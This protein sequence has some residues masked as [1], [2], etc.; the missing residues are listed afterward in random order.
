MDGSLDIDSANFGRLIRSNIKPRNVIIQKNY[1]NSNVLIERSTRYANSMAAPIL[2]IAGA[3][4]NEIVHHRGR[5]KKEM[6]DL[7]ERFASYIEKVRFLEAQNRKLGDELERLKL[8]W[9]K[10]TNNIKLMYQTELDEAKKLLDDS[11]KD[12]KKL[13]M[14][15]SAME[16]Q[17]EMIRRKLEEA[18]SAVMDSRDKVEKQIQQLADYEAEVN[19]IKRRVALL[20]GDRE[21][22]KRS[23][24]RIQDCLN[25]ARIDLDNESL[26]HQDA[27]NRR[28]NLEEE[29]EFLKQIHEQELRELAELAYRDTTSENR[30]LWKNEMSSSLRQ[31]QQLYD[32]KVEDMKKEVESFYM[33]K[34]QE[35]RTGATRQNLDSV[36]TKEEMVRLRSQFSDLQ[37]KLFEL[38]AKNDNIQREI[39]EMQQEKMINERELEGENERLIAEIAALKAEMDS[40]TKEL[41]NLL[42]AKLGLELEIAAYR[43]LLEGEDNKVGLR[44]VVDSMFAT[45]T[46][47]FGGRGSNE[48]GS[49]TGERLTGGGGERM[50][51]GGGGGGGVRSSG[52]GMSSRATYNTTTTQMGKNISA[53]A[54]GYGTDN[55]LNINQVVKGDMLAKTTYQRSAKGPAAISESSPDGKFITLENNGRREEYLGNWMI[56]R[57]VDGREMAV[58]NLPSD[59]RIQPDSKAKIYCRGEKPR[60]S[61]YEDIEL[62]TCPT[63]GKG[64]NVTTTLC[65]ASGEEKATQVQRTFYA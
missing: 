26:L 16:D 15:V 58:A 44:Q 38:Q 1:S 19:L 24:A 46:T 52:G 11:E 62:Y 21:Q 14:R 53:G 27:E 43:K 4:V 10:E 50:S 2:S 7:N 20:E 45:M 18:T 57:N 22:N 56:R 61:G 65:N 13:Q 3:G 36:H 5:E 8:K 63:F 6:Q 47:G 51:S 35:Y 25:R 30:E 54:K 9:G 31:M 40:I 12:K 60:D 42:D 48:A 28:Q 59:F 64:H 37:S 32:D 23:L 41:Q 29:L 17:V 39:D 55:T 34:V 49:I 33:M